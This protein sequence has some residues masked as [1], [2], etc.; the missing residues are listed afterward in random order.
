MLFFFFSMGQM[1]DFFS[2]L[3]NKFDS[4]FFHSSESTKVFNS[5]S[6][7][8]HS[9]SHA[10]TSTYKQAKVMYLYVMPNFIHFKI[11]VAMTIKR[12]KEKKPRFFFCCCDVKVRHDL[13]FVVIFL[14][15]IPYS[16]QFSHYAMAYFLK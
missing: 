15:F 6:V 11:H 2:Y 3:E 1:K 10:R 5:N 14:S 13:I 9:L 4:F 8:F 7:Y 12:P 16:Y